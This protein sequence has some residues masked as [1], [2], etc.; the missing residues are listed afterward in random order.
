[1][2][3]DKERISYLYQQY[4]SNKLT[5]E[6][7]LD[8]KA[9]LADESLQ[10]TLKALIDA[11]YYALPESELQDM[12]SERSDE[13]FHH[14]SQQ[15]DVKAL[16]KI[17]WQNIAA[18]AAIILVL[19]LG[20][21]FYQYRIQGETANR[22]EMVNDIGP[23][24]NRATLKLADGKLIELS[25]TQQAILIQN[26]NLAYQDGSSLTKTKA[27]A[28]GNLSL[29]TPRGG[30]YQVVLPDGTK[31]WL[32]SA[33]TLS[34]P[35]DFAGT[36]QHRL[37]KLSGE[38][39]FEVAKDHLRPFVVATASQNVEVLGTHFNLSSYPGEELTTTTLLEGRVH[40]SG[41]G[42][43]GDLLPGQQS[44]LQS[45][46]NKFIIVTANL[47]SAVAWK[48]GYFRFDDE[49]IDEIMHKLSRWYDIE[50][51]YE[52]AVST[53]KFSGNISRN[54][55]ISEVLNM[56]SY[57]RDVRFRVEGRRVTVMK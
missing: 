56:L 54:I 52:G 29:S 28:Q 8:W 36:S 22:N 2:N 20:I 7:E 44:L 51:V 23:G 25:S 19:G 38:A 46:N 57:S 39:Y 16:K 4:L 17:R 53:E 5:A 33:S 10:D 40:I 45:K 26:K 30:T 42:I 12:G 1:M 35:A 15:V 41:K 37:V 3:I 31:V 11:S 49:R 47:K 14:I 50:V 32:N 27:I 9:V 6:E 48:N 34:F 55:N 21:G 18:A 24:K 13:I 43:G